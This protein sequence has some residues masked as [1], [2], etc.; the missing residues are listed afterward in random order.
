MIDYN[1]ILIIQTAFIGDAILASSLVE[2]LHRYFPKA[3]ITIL[4][5]KGNESIYEKHP[6]L[7]EVLVWNKK[8]NKISNLFK[9]LFQ[10]RKNKYD[11]VINCHRYASSGFLT[12]F[13]GAHHTAGYKENPFSFLFNFN[14]KHLIGNGLHET[15]RYNQ[16]IE[17]FTDKTVF[18]PKLYLSVSDFETVKQFQTSSYICIAPASVW[19]TKQLPKEKWIELCNNTNA[20]TNI[21]VLGAPNDLE[22]CQ[23][24]QKESK[25]TNIKILAG[26]LSLLQSCA[27]MK[28]AKMNFV[29]DS[30]PLHLASAINAP[31]TAFFTSTVPAFGFGPLADNSNI[32]EVEGLSCKPCGIH[33]YKA[34]PQGHFKCGYL[35]DLSSIKND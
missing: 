29:N 15:E 18:K 30:A 21:Y 22:L 1:N 27:L 6:F 10:I 16:L 20:N 35:M 19:F 33:G 2:K 12:A 28:D 3:N 31:V 25:H 32:I 14:I 23:Q 7:K 11:C 34:C 4:V 5:R 8:E 26:K 17:D 13:S 9:L 24:I